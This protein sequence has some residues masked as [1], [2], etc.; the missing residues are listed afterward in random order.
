MRRFLALML[1][2]A[3]ALAPSAA[4]AAVLP[5]VEPAIQTS[6]RASRDAALVIGNEGYRELPQATYAGLDAPAFQDWLVRSLGIRTRSVSSVQG[7]SADQMRSEVK[8]AARK[9]SKGG[10]LWVYYAGHGTLTDDGKRALVGIDASPDDIGAGSLPLAELAAIVAKE[11]RV[12]RVMLVVDAGFG[13]LSRDGIE[14][15]P[16]RSVALSEDLATL[17]DKVVPWLADGGAAT[18]ASFGPGKHGQ[19][20]WLV[21]GALRGWAD[22]EVNGARDAKVT[23]EEAQAYVAWRVRNLGRDSSPTR[24]SRQDVQSI[25]LIGG[26]FFEQSPPDDFF[27]VVSLEDRQRRFNEAETRIRAEANAFWQDTLRIAGQG[28]PTAKKAL[29]AFIKEYEDAVVTVEW[30]LALPEVK[31]ARQVLGNIDSKGIAAVAE[32]AIEPCDDLVAMESAASLG[33]LS[34][35]QRNCLEKRISSERL[36]TKKDNIS[37]VLIANAEVGNDQPEWE[38]L[39]QRHLEAID[40]SDPNLCFRYA[41]YLHKDAVSRAP[42]AIKWADYALSNRQEWEGEE[43]VKRV[44]GLYRLRAEAASRLWEDAEQTYT[45]SRSPESEAGSAKYRGW[46]MNYAR[47][48]LDYARAAAINIDAAYKLCLSASGTEGFCKEGAAPLQNDEPVE[49][50]VEGAE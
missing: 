13:P 48:W 3:L 47:E 34:R 17:P 18:A 8:K 15:V 31:A 26:K 45:A 35:G 10:A 32:A 14:L 19:F 21:L 28:G 4:P 5:D 2:S 1:L 30:G 12:A 46:T 36:Q 41:L 22:G 39:M 16:G 24:D 7:A 29:E 40:R 23:I 38:R 33:Q 6:E 20:T 50:A 43:H 11:R 42:E 37:R 9:V 25:V 49:E 27:S 44:S